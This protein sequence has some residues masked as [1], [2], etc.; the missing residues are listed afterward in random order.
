MGKSGDYS[1]VIL[2]K[3]QLSAIIVSDLS[4]DQS[5]VTTSACA[6]SNEASEALIQGL[7]KKVLQ[8]NNQCPV[9]KVYIRVI[10]FRK[11]ITTFIFF[12]CSQDT[13]VETQSKVW[14]YFYWDTNKVQFLKNAQ[15]SI[16]LKNSAESPSCEIVLDLVLVSLCEMKDSGDGNLS[17]S[18]VSF[19]ANAQNVVIN[20]DIS[21]ALPSIYAKRNH[22]GSLPPILIQNNQTVNIIKNP[23]I[24]NGGASGGTSGGLDISGLGDIGITAAPPTE[25]IFAHIRKTII[26]ILFNLKAGLTFHLIC[27]RIHP[28]NPSKCINCSE[29]IKKVGN[30]TED[31]SSETPVPPCNSLPWKERFRQ[32][33]KICPRTH[34]YNPL[35][36]LSCPEV[37]KSDMGLVDSVGNKAKDVTGFFRSTVSHIFKTIKYRI[38]LVLHTAGSFVMKFGGDLVFCVKENPIHPLSWLTCKY[39]L[40]VNPIED[41]T[42]ETAIKIFLET[43]KQCVL[44]HLDQPWKW[45]KCSRICNNTGSVNEGLVHDVASGVLGTNDNGGTIVNVG[46][47][48]GVNAKNNLKSLE[49][50]I[51]CIA[52]D[53]TKLLSCV[54]N[55][56]QNS[57]S[58]S[59]NKNGNSTSQQSGSNESSSTENSSGSSSTES[60]SESKTEK[61]S[62]SSSTEKSSES[63]SPENSS[64]SSNT[65][66]SSG[67]SSTENSSEKSSSDNT[68]ESSGS[69][70]SS[71]SSSESSGSDT[72]SESS[73]ENNSESSSDSSSGSNTDNRIG[74][75][76]E[77]SNSDSSSESD[78]ATI[79][80]R[81]LNIRAVISRVE[82]LIKNLATRVRV[83]LLFV[84]YKLSYFFAS[85]RSYVGKILNVFQK[86]IRKHMTKLGLCLTNNPT[87][88]TKWLSCDQ[89]KAYLNGNLTQPSQTPCMSLEPKEKLRNAI[90]TCVWVHLTSPNHWY[91][92]LEVCQ[93]NHTKLG[94]V[95]YRLELLI[96]DVENSVASLP[97]N[98]SAT[99][100]GNVK[101]LLS[102]FGITDLNLS[103]V[104]RVINS[105]FK[106]VADA[107]STFL[108]KRIAFI[109]NL[110]KNIIMFL[111]GDIKSGKMVGGKLSSTLQTKLQSIMSY[112]KNDFNFDLKSL[113]KIGKAI[114][115][116]IGSIVKAAPGKAKSIITGVFKKIGS[117]FAKVKY[118]VQMA[119]GK[120]GLAIKLTSNNGGKGFS[121]TVQ[122]VARL[123]LRIPMN[124]FRSINNVGTHIKSTLRVVKNF[125]TLNFIGIREAVLNLGICIMKN[126]SS[127]FNYWNCP[128]YLLK[129]GV[130]NPED[131][132]DIGSGITANVTGSGSLAKPT[133][134]FG[135]IEYFLQT[136]LFG[137]TGIFKQVESLIG[138][139]IFGENGKLRDIGANIFG[140]N[141]FFGKLFAFLKFDIFGKTGI[142]GGVNGLVGSG[143]FGE[144]GLLN[145]LRMRIFGKTGFF[146]KLKDFLKTGI[147]GKTGIFSKV[148]DLVKNGVF[149]GALS[150]K[151]SGESGLFG[152]L[153]TF[154]KNDL[155]GSQ[156]VF[157]RLKTLIGGGIFS[158]EDGLIKNILGDIAGSNGF[159]G[160]LKVFLKSDLA[161]Q[162]G[163]LGNVGRLLKDGIFSKTG[164]LGQL[165][166]NIAG[167]NGIF[168]KIFA[169]LKNNVFGGKGIFSNVG[170]LIFSDDGILNRIRLNIF[171][172]NGIIAKIFG[173]F[174]FGIFGENGVFAKIFGLFRYGIFGDNGFIGRILGYIRHRIIGDNG[175]VGRIFGFFKNNVFDRIK[176]IISSITGK[177][178]NGASGNFEFSVGKKGQGSGGS[179]G[180]SSAGTGGGGSE[181][182][183][184]GGG[185]SGGGFSSGGGSSGAESGGNG[186][187]GFSFKFG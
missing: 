173:F 120:I 9:D 169:F 67:N 172:G 163:V 59:E 97:K 101:S 32:Y 99:I 159:L 92:C 2:N 115:G 43:V 111:K 52:K 75:E 1:I 153:K 71:Q 78:S 147:F 178:K 33:M 40:E 129:G 126:P 100:E 177:F 124:I 160:K 164:L 113:G 16:C 64:E 141:G 82:S 146:G 103:N 51:K 6:C 161:G 66:K 168:G 122:N 107:I 34:Y 131:I 55:G 25:S 58:S 90:T 29:G 142:F 137:K 61:S 108:N 46:K 28:L 139:N 72:S 31:S 109:K 93:S 15:I 23:I 152:R 8:Q 125:I 85:V 138:G 102:R 63:N 88:P 136:H 133:G 84:R 76:S 69:D 44:P 49:S 54:K 68:S 41:C 105:K 179:N 151:F 26:S 42:N 35:M 174:K 119:L 162:K 50:T 150:G 86:N 11:T 24:I 14:L 18:I 116:Q 80:H 53:P 185:N 77:N 104:G 144:Q 81:F 176:N 112:F 158:K 98:I 127:P 45:L 128:Q 170:K 36:W 89:Y 74:D 106:G 17:P 167:E 155:F 20:N 38:Q 27:F 181:S 37:C 91:N 183:S 60:S 19:G 62:G 87:S 3:F 10:N 130:A 180:D 143:L 4:E 135:K 56:G 95:R 134:V 30:K 65:E 57:T 12:F 184:S 123:I 70:N 48:I 22:S 117:I 154:F 94:V 132:N 110:P 145:K 157:G 175:I 186:G 7:F 13:T 114:I 156:G 149:K 21:L 83:S 187:G 73:S 5:T 148:A 39:K 121:G 96:R 165:Q 171:G 166:T 118:N 79:R 182:G 47:A 140:E